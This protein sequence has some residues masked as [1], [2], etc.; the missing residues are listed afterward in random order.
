MPSF[1]CF[2]TAGPRRSASGFTQKQGI[3]VDEGILPRRTRSL[4]LIVFRRP[5]FARE[6]TRRELAPLL[7]TTS[8]QPVC[9]DCGANANDERRNERSQATRFLALKSLLDRLGHVVR[10]IRRLPRRAPAHPNPR[11]ASARPRRPS[12]ST[13]CPGRAG[14][15]RRNRRQVPLCRRFR[16]LAVS[17]LPRSAPPLP[18]RR[19]GATRPRG[20]VSVASGQPRCAESS[21]AG[22]AVTTGSFAGG[23]SAVGRWS[24]RSG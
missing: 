2:S 24:R 15:P 23:R 8:E 22:R 1:C 18:P 13:R 5:A 17:P 4:D 6:R 10:H 12:H 11:R 14:V 21:R 19:E 7:V 9:H 20:V 3:L 16:Y